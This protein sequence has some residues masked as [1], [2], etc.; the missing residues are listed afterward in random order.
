MGNR[1]SLYRA[2]FPSIAFLLVLTT[3]ATAQNKALGNQAQQALFQA[4]AAM[5]VHAEIRHD[6]SPPLSDLVKMGT[7]GAMASSAAQPLPPIPLPFR[8]LALQQ[9][10]PVRQTSIAAATPAS[11][12]AVLNNFDGIGQDV[13]GFTVQAAPSDTSA[14]VGLT[15]YV[16]WVNFSFAVFDKTTGNI[17][18][19]YPVPG[20]TLWQGFGG[21]CETNN[22][23]DPIVLYDRLNDRWILAQFAIH[24]GSQFLTNTFECIAVSTTSDATGSYNRYAF[25]YNNAINNDPKLAVWPD[26]YYATFNL[27]DP[28]T[29][30]FIGAEAC[31]YDGAAMRAGQSASQICFPQPS[32]VANLLP[33]DV[34]GHNPP[35]PGSPDFM[36]NFDVNS[37]NLYK[38]H[39][40][41]AAP[42]NSTFS[43]ATNIP[44]GAFTPLCFGAAGCVPQP[45]TSV[46]LDSLA[47][48][49]MYRVAYRNFGDHESL[50]VN[51]SVAV[52]GTANSGSGVRWYEIQDPNGTPVVTQQSTFSPDAN[53][54]W[55]GSISIDISGDIAV[56]YSVSSNT[57][58]PSIAIAG[59][60]ASDPPGAL[61]SEISIVSGAGSQTFDS[62]GA[63]LTRWGEYSSMQLDPADDCTFWYSTEYMQTTGAFNWNTRIANF[64]FPFCGQTDLTISKTHSGAFTQ[65]DLGKTYTLTVTNIGPIDTDGSTVTVTDTLPAGLTAT[66]LSGT[67]WTCDVP[68]LTCTRTDVLAARGSYPAITLTVNVAGN[69]PSSVT[70]SATVS[71]GGEQNTTNN[72]ASDQTTIIQTGPDPAITK[73]HDGNFQQGQTG[74][75]TI[76][77]TNA[78]LSPTD[79][80]TVTV[81]DT[82]PTG[83]TAQSASGTGWNCVLGTPV[84]CTRLDALA[85]KAAYPAITLVVNVANNAPASVTNTATVSGGGD[86][87]LANDTASDLTSIA[88]GLPDL[89]I[90]MS[91]FPVNLSQ[92]EPNAMYGIRVS[93]VGGTPTSGTITVT[94][95]LP[96]GLTLSSSS[97]FGWDC[98]LIGNTITCTRSDSLPANSSFNPGIGVFA[99]VAVNA[100]SLVINTATVSGGGEVNTANDIV[101]D[102]ANIIPEPKMGIKK[103]HFPDPFVVGQTGTYNIVVSDVGGASTNAQVTVVDNMP[104]G[105]SVTA[106]TATGWNCSA[107]PATSVS[108][109][110]SDVLASGGSYP[111]ITMTVTVNGG[112]SPVTNQATVSG[113]GEV[114]SS[115]DTASDVTNIVASV[116]SIGPTTNTTVTVKAGTQGT[117]GFSAGLP[118]NAGQVTF[119]ADSLPANSNATFNPTSLSQSGSVTLTVDTS[120]NGHTAM[121]LRPAGFDRRPLFLAGFFVFF[122]FLAARAGRRQRSRWAWASCFCALVCVLSMVACGGGGAG[123]G[124][125]V[126]TPTPTPTGVTPPGTYTITVTATS[127][128]A[129]LPPVST[130]VTLVVQ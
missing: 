72:T 16:Q 30:D 77:V 51:H 44:V 102:A 82:L 62:S 87:N 97:H 78:G 120:G 101:S 55:M 84:S 7:T 64:K 114:I 95:T 52:G 36:L 86:V 100:P 117:F 9:S 35:P 18:P 14:A 3:A 6:V 29:T 89:A 85:S 63:P 103:S 22:D 74:T 71:G 53:F 69:A 128:N 73:T 92:G 57:V 65:G 1:T 32:T 42:G 46:Q 76:T 61:G 111:A 121:L 26:A 39:V 93:N 23:G 110:R 2:L 70:N 115:N 21:P 50:V 107:P 83:L 8:F 34:E 129:A 75:Y 47:D 105:L 56:G 67:G 91:H 124:G 10:D 108:C 88:P 99:N 113:G 37:L 125:G 54:R 130:P 41:F 5:T 68:S 43:D 118:A 59:R 116:L 40:D 127:S 94:D 106:L 19:N 122:A 25:E 58:F 66:N 109:S 38:F 27:F 20:N 4:R 48:R 31:A 12:P 112:V 119:S 17:L 90:T 28:V 15:Q 96:A 79:G 13:F 80:T 24:D 123:G 45:N 104:A 60:T 81:T 33:S 11:G 126:P 49:L 98:T